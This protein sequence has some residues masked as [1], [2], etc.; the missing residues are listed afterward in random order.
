ME[1]LEYLRALRRRWLIVVA[2]AVVAGAAAWVTA[3]PPESIP[4]QRTFRAT[5]TLFDDPNSPG[6]L[7]VGLPT[8]ALL[9]RTGEIPRRVVDELG[10]TTEPQVLADQMRIETD[11]SVGVITITADDRDGEFAAR[12][13]NTWARQLLLFFEQRQAT[14]YEERAER[15]LTRRQELEEQ[16]RAVDTRLRQSAQDSVDY[17]LLLSERDALTRQYGVVTEQYASLEQSQVAGLGIVSL[18]QAVPVPVTE[19]GFTVPTNRD[20]RGLMGA[21]M[22]LLLG[23]TVA[24]FTDRVDTRV[25]DRR[26]A[27]SAFRHPVLTEVPVVRRNQG[28][29][30][31]VAQPASFA[32]ESY[33][34]L[35]LSLQMA[36]RWVQAGRSPRP[37]GQRPEVGSAETNGDHGGEQRDAVK[38]V[39][40]TSGGPGE[41]KSTSVANI[42]ASYAEIGKRVLVLDC[43]FRNPQQH[44]L[45]DVARS[46]GVAEY[47]TRGPRRPALASLSQATAVPG[48]RLVPNGTLVDNPGELIGPDQ[49]L[50]A[51]ARELADV[52]L[53]DAGPVLAVNDPAALLP[54]ADAVV[55][56]ARCGKTNVDTAGRTIDL[57][58]RMGAPVVGVAL[59]AVPRSASGQPYY[60]QLRSVPGP[61]QRRWRSGGTPTPRTGV[62][63]R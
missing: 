15:L 41:G 45:F 56:I 55:V 25:R 42:A 50:I 27:E 62:T 53:V 36:N 8:M 26:T 58:T 33:R 7:D 1:P 2:A 39:L 11:P 60:A 24:L 23:A 28:R 37:A 57:L 22:G 32:A 52:V 63:G 43:D 14:S 13:A 47:L 6:S 21:A 19:G 40:V 44:H 31:T 20:A 59:V 49:D 17:E 18:E 12:L 46:P 3:P 35:R 29:I 51:E 38:V 61:A 30:I 4:E 5:H 16:A 54:Q 10:V 34:I 9:A 48:V